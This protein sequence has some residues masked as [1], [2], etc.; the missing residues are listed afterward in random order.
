[1]IISK[2]V[3][4]SAVLLGCPGQQ[5][6]Y[7]IGVKYDL[8]NFRQFLMSEQGGAFYNS[9]IK[10]VFDPTYA[11]VIRIIKESTSDY[12]ITYFSGHGYTDVKDL[13]RK[14]CLHDYSIQDFSLFN[15]SPRQI[16]FA[17]A[18]RVHVQPGIGAIPGLSEAWSEFSG[19]PVR[20]IL[21]KF[22]SHSP[23]GKMIIHGT[24]SGELSY[25]EG[26]GGSFT[27]ALLDVSSSINTPHDYSPVSMKN[28]LK[29]LP[30]VLRKKGNHQVPEITYQEGEILIPFAFGM[31]QQAPIYKQKLPVRLPVQQQVNWAGVGLLA[32][33]IWAI[34]ASD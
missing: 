22:I 14:L 13:S 23:A 15:D 30:S 8:E 27:K 1:M 28:I 4:R 21:D 3:T 24:Q 19:S 6:K 25:D 2:R 31:A 7:L 32:L 20:E 26:D 11:K 9:E 12:C 18:C 33:C 29:H 17:D 34:A 16:I 10:V 5:N